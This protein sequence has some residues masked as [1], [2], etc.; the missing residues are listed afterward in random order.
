MKLFIAPYKMGSESAKALAQALN[1]KR[2]DGTKI[3]P[4]NTTIINWGRDNLTLR[5]RGGLRILNSNTSVALAKNKLYTLETLQQ[6]GVSIP[7]WTTSKHTVVDWLRNDGYAYARRHLVGQ[8]GSG[9][10]I[11]TADVYEVPTCPLYTKAIHKAHEYRVHVAGG[12]VID[13]SKKKRKAGSDSSGLIKNSVNGWVFCRDGVDLP[14]VVKDQALKALA[15]V[16][17]D[18]GALDIVYKERDNKAYVLEI[19]TAPGIE[20]TTLDRYVEYFRGSR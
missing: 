13:Y 4:F 2:I 6:H 1:V 7:D 19:N 8:Q 20:G 3:M 16:G 11:V 18:F 12:N 9:I 10:E 14:V 15:A 5:N 17:L